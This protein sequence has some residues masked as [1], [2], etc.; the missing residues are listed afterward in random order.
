M[1]SSTHR[2]ALAQLFTL[3]LDCLPASGVGS[4]G[5]VAEVDMASCNS[6]GVHVDEAVRERRCC[7]DALGTHVLCE[8]HGCK[9]DEWRA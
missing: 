9:E 1:P 4:G 7:A 5:L 3:V 2:M 6:S 8:G